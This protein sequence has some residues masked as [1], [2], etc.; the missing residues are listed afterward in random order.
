MKSRQEFLQQNLS[1]IYNRMKKCN[2]SIINSDSMYCSR[3]GVAPFLRNMHEDL[4][5]AFDVEYYYIP[6]SWKKSQNAY[7]FCWENR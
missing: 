4:S 1:R 7:V 6:D 5:K 3:G 2:L